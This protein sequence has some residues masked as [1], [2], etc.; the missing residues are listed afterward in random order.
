M[1]IQRLLFRTGL[2]SVALATGCGQDVPPSPE[3]VSSGGVKTGYIRLEKDGQPRQVTFTDVEGRAM[4]EGDIVL[5]PTAEVA[6]KVPPGAD[7][8]SELSAQGIAITGSG[9][10]WPGGVVPFVIDPAL[11]DAGRV[12]N[13]IAH[14]EARTNVR[15]VERTASNASRYPNHLLFRALDGCWSNVGMRGGEQVVSLGTGCGTVAAI[16]EIGHAIGLWHEQSREDRDGHVRIR[17]ENIRSGEEHNFNQHI[18][19]GD[20][21]GTYD[22]SSIMHYDSYAFSRNGQPTIERLDGGLIG[23]NSALS[24]G[25]L[26]AI[27]RLYP[28]FVDPSAPH[29]RTGDYNGDGRT[30]WSWYWPRASTFVVAL[31]N[32]DGSVTRVYNDTSGWGDWTNG[33]FFSTG[34]FNGDGR[35]DWSWYAP[36][37]RDFIV[38]FSNGDGRF[39]AVGNNTSGWGEWSNGRFF[40]T[41]DFNGDGRADWSWYAPWSRDFIVMFSNGDGHFSAVGNNT[42]GWGEWSN[43]RFFSTGDFNGDGRTDWS[44]YAPWSRDFIVMFSNGDGHFSAV[45]NNTSGWGD[46]SNGR[47]FSTGDYNG[48]GRT[49]W[50]WYAPWSNDFIV[51]FSNGDGHFSAVGNNTSGWGNWS[52]GAHFRT[53]DYNG[54][55]RTDWSWYAPWSADFIVMK[56]NG[57]GGFFR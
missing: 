34:D 3:L 38:M 46:W 48:D 55:G 18:S 52:N 2:L 42:S 10:R 16:H 47:F 43:G 22:F 44:W 41:G 11:P 26:A 36:W 30:D 15:F 4:F 32:A 17:W 33:R 31:S 20:D 19:D 50:S 29:F 37:S 49:D 27:Q 21:L 5:G 54:D 24:A 45:G 53:G 51:M 8:V 40:S 57:A 6:V 14:W 56:S 13:A 35:T 39:S 9:Y 28:H 12:R 1:R 7:P 25:D 23:W